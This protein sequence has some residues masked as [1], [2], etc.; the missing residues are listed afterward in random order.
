M[1][2]AWKNSNG[3]LTK[4]SFEFDVFSIFESRNRCARWA[5]AQRAVIRIDQ[6]KS[7]CPM[8][9]RWHAEVHRDRTAHLQL[10]CTRLLSSGAFHPKSAITWLYLWAQVEGFVRPAR[11]LG[12]PNLWKPNCW[13]TLLSCWSS[14]DPVDLCTCETCKLQGFEWSR[15][16]FFERALNLPLGRYIWFDV[17]LLWHRHATI[18]RGQ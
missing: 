8:G 7:R 10:D 4:L 18:Q 14:K 17:F 6:G 1:K 12:G 15:F 13:P 3:K 5:A 9:C 11:S 2:T 16:F